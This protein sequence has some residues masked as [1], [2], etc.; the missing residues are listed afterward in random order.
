MRFHFLIV[1]TLYSLFLTAQQTQVVS[2]QTSNTDPV[3]NRLVWSDDFNGSGAI[4]SEK[5]FHQT[6]LPNGDSWY[7]NEI[8]HYTNRTVNTSVSNGSLHLVAKKETFTDQGRTK[9]YT[10]ARLNSKFAF[11]YGKVEVRAILPTGVGTWP[12]IWMLG[13]NITE[14]GGYWTSSY[15]TT[16]WPACGEIDIMEHWGRNPNYVQSAMHTP[17]SFGGTI[18]HGGQSISTA[19]TEF[20]IYTLEWYED[21][22]VFKVDGV[23][24]YTYAPDSLDAS[25][26]PFDKD[27]YIL[28]NIAI[29]QSISPSFE[30]SEMTIDYVKVYQQATAS[31]GEIQAM[32]TIQIFPNPID[33]KVRIEIQ[34]ELIGVKG[35]IYSVLG[36]KMFSF[37]QD[38]LKK[39]YDFSGLTKGIYIL[40]FNSKMNTSSYK[41]LKK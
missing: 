18:N 31:V 8:Q 4:D 2:T 37:V 26:W 17:S 35:T 3:Y 36:Q 1:C 33:D 10:S 30:E 6:Q 28:L 11:T 23:E 22:M 27:Q 20:H 32:N 34:P 21:K 9:Q 13:K 40:K 15:G 12:A 5:W 7:N 19:T 29:E 14:P 24:H 41:V 16:P 38:S 39:E 25:T